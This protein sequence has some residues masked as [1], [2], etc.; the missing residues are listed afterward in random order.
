VTSP[1]TPLQHGEYVAVGGRDKKVALYNLTRR[2]Y[3]GQDVELAASQL[4]WEA[5]S[6]DFVY[7]VALSPDR[8]YCAYGGTAAVVSVVDGHTGRPL[9]SVPTS[10]TIWCIDFLHLVDDIDTMRKM[11]VGGDFVEL[12]DFDLTTQKNEL[13]LRASDDIA[14]GVTITRDSVGFTQGDKVCVYGL[15]G[16]RYAWWDQPS[17]QHASQLLLSAAGDL[18][19]LQLSLE[20]NPS[21]ANARSGETGKNLLEFAVEPGQSTVLLDHLL[22]ADCKLGLQAN[23]SGLCAVDIALSHNKISALRRLLGALLDSRLQVTPSSMAMVARCLPKIR[24]KYP[25]DF[26]HLWVRSSCSQS[27]RSS[28]GRRRTT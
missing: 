18:M 6:A 28:A 17:F 24:V 20:A 14:F 11:V 21:M 25:R 9:W 4:V 27:L 2:D 13:R 15:G 5:T 3:G 16:T 12:N 7:S 1:P 26:L 10:G 8:Q 22:H 19:S 23:A